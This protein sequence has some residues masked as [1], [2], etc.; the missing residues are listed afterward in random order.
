M[1]TPIIDS[2]ATNLRRRYSPSELVQTGNVEIL[3]WWS[4]GFC[5]VWHVLPVRWQQRIGIISDRCPHPL[6]NY[7]LPRDPEMLGCTPTLYQELIQRFDSNQ[8]PQL[9]LERLEQEISHE[10]SVRF[11]K[12]LLDYAIEQQASD[13]H[14]EPQPQAYRLRLR[15][16]GVLHMVRTLSRNNAELLFN[17]FKVLAKLNLAEQRL[18]LNGQ[19]IH[20]YYDQQQEIRVAVIPESS[21]T[22]MVLRLFHKQTLFREIDQ[23]GFNAQQQPMWMRAVSAQNGLILLTGPTGSGKTTTLYST[24]LH[25]A[26]LNKKIC[27]VEDPVEIIEPLFCQIQVH[28]AI[29]LD[30]PTALQNL[31]RH[32]PDVLLIGE[33][34]DA[35]T[36][37]IAVQAALTGHLVFA[38]LHTADVAGAI[39]RMLDLDV[40]EL[41][42]RTTL[43]AVVA[44]RLLRT[45]CQSCA[46]TGCATC[47]QTGLSGRVPIVEFADHHMLSV[48]SAMFTGE[49]IRAHLRSSN[50]ISLRQQ[51]MALVATNQTTVAEVIAQTPD[52]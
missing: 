52:E 24:L 8:S 35:Q 30:F 28:E 14:I 5:R 2:P 18:P 49:H 11:S 10:E 51:A 4:A 25:L 20:A 27:T 36:A 46:G 40:P 47:Y 32:D 34:R 50:I 17:R 44:Q 19:F 16:D 48:P 31:L 39:D 7:T 3:P 26:K 15:V 21:G 33:I 45:T 22:M 13:I 23:L 29:G 1:F 9:L 12:W 42:L 41:L 37:K 38:S 43:R 6:V